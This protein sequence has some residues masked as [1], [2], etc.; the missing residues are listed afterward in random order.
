[1][2]NHNFVY[3]LNIETSSLKLDESFLALN[4][5]SGTVAGYGNGLRTSASHKA[6][7]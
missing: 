5:A 2:K 6:S 1:M 7:E 3:I 4:R